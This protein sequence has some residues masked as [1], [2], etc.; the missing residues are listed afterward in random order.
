MRL[1]IVQAHWVSLFVFEKPRSGSN[2]KYFDWESISRGKNPSN[3]RCPAKKT[4]I[5]RVTTNINPVSKIIP[6]LLSTASYMR[7]RFF[8]EFGQPYVR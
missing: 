3:A 7:W 1:Q 2:P 6:M 8:K 4:V 5:I